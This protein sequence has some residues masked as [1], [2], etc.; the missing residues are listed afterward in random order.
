MVSIIARIAVG[1]LRGWD[2]F[3]QSHEQQDNRK[4]YLD[5]AL[6][7]ALLLELQETLNPKPKL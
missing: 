4:F 6:L 3:P 2:P 1:I 7:T 5:L